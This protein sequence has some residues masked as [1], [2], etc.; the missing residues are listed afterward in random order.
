MEGNERRAVEARIQTLRNI[1]VLL[2]AA[3]LQFQQYLG[4]VGGP[5]ATVG[6]ENIGGNGENA[7]QNRDDQPTTSSAEGRES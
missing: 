6:R 1:S 2:D 3:L 5:P 4:G 7:A